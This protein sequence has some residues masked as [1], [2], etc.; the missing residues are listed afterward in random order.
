MLPKNLA[1]KIL[2]YFGKGLCYNELYNSHKWR[3]ITT[4]DSYGTL[5]VGPTGVADG[6]Q[7]WSRGV[8]QSVRP[9]HHQGGQR[10]RGQLAGGRQSFQ[11]TNRHS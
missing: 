4:Y 5:D 8:D 3:Y 11:T 9:P 2:Y 10:S 7:H 6:D 1:S